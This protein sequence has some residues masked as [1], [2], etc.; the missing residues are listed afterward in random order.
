M[1]Q[2]YKVYNKS[3]NSLYEVY[4]FNENEIQYRRSDGGLGKFSRKGK[5][6]VV[7]LLQFSGLVDKN[8]IE[9]YDGHIY[10]NT[11]NY[12]YKVMFINGSFVGGKNEDRCLPLGWDVDGSDLVVLDDFPSTIEVVGNIFQN[13]E[14]LEELAADNQSDIR[15]I[16]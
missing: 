11:K 16:S 4:G 6:K 9:I 5:N 3:T 14:L 10:R 15:T 12:L 13:P 1:K 8:G 2:K 7:T